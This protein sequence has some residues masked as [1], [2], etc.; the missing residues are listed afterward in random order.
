MHC[1]GTGCVVA[2]QAHQPWPCL[3]SG[4]HRWARVAFSLHAS[5]AKADA[6]T[7]GADLLCRVLSSKNG[8]AT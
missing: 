2:E 4:P 5:E 1:F 7:S 3:S 6:D 8:A